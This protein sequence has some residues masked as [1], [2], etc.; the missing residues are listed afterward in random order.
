M[1]DENSRAGSGFLSDLC[2]EWEAAA[3]PARQAG[4]SILHLRLG[5]VF[6]TRGGMLKKVVPLFKS[7]L[8]GVLG[9]GRQ[10]LS[11]IT[12]HDLVRMFLFLLDHPE[13]NGPI[14]AVSPRPVTNREF[15]RTLAKLLHRPALAPFPAWAIRGLLGEQGTA[16]FLAS[17]RVVPARLIESGFQFQ[18][19]E[20]EEGLRHE[21]ESAD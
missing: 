14:N 6:S 21:L 4:I 5:V 10:Y 11:W 3:E 7:G 17:Q 2:Q 18:H 19:A 9:N 1:L 13:L 15:T 12:L 8:G 16:L 20:L